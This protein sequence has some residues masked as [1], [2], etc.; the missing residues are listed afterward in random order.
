MG[1]RLTEKRF[2]ASGQGRVYLAFFVLTIFYILLNRYDYLVGPQKYF[3]QKIL[4]IQN[5]SWYLRDILTVL[6]NET[7]YCFLAWPLAFLNK[8]IDLRWIFFVGH[9][10]TTF[11][12]LYA[13]YVL[14]KTIFED[15]RIAFLS[16][17]GVFVIKPVLIDASLYPTVFYHRYVSWAL[18]IFSII[19]FLRR[20]PL[21]S[22]LLLGLGFN[23]T[24]YA[25]A[26]LV[27]MYTF[28]ILVRRKDFPFQE[29]L[30][31][32]GSFSVIA[33]PMLF[34][35]LSTSGDIPVIKPPEEWLAL[36]KLTTAIYCFPSA[37]WQPE[38]GQLACFLMALVWPFLFLASFLKKF[39]RV[40]G[41]HQMI[42]YLMGAVLFL[43]FLG[44]I[45]SEIW[46]VAAVLQLQLFRAHRFFVLF[47]ILYFTHYLS[48]RY[49]E[50]EEWPAR[51][52]VAVIMTAFVASKMILC[53]ALTAID[54]ILRSNW[55]GEKLKKTFQSAAITLLGIGALIPGR[56][57]PSL[58]NRLFHLDGFFV[59]AC[60]LTFVFLDQFF[61]PSL[62]VKQGRLLGGGLIYA[63]LLVL[64]LLPSYWQVE[65]QFLRNP[66]A[67]LSSQIEWPWT[68]KMG[69]EYKS[70]L[71]WVNTQTDQNALF[72]NPPDHTLI[73]YFKVAT[74]RGEVSSLAGGI[75]IAS[76]KY[77]R[78]WYQRMLDL[79]GIPKEKAMSRYLLL[80]PDKVKK[81]RKS[82]V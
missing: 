31:L 75:L 45:F 18:Q 27:L 10:V 63:A 1:P 23:I 80:T 82:V 64:V 30:K 26:H 12:Y 66:L 51:S 25:A 11:F 13:V 56:F 6:Q 36:L 43:F 55:I 38:N 40:E 58:V 4:S 62:R 49:L 70:L 50:Q 57:Q 78:E 79:E 47:S 68:M 69:P 35:R 20:S 65:K 81:D 41:T 52:W 48:S 15:S 59:A 22:G 61:K 32:A 33:A 9:F 16:V 24:P 42:G 72:L 73:K 7:Y 2:E 37:L 28:V 46:P 44:T 77:G 74:G 67:T 17:M 39:L 21:A 5:P 19:Y 60:V 3:A 14:A 76:L 8:W 54:F 71:N 29:V 53:V 34:F